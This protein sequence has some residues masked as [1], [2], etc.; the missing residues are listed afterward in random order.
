MT[1]D[2]KKE[3]ILRVKKMNTILRKLYP[4]AVIALN[5]SNP[6]ELMV[7]VQLSAQ[8]TDKRVNI[9]TEKLFKKYTTVG[10]YA[11]ARQVEF[12]KDIFSCGFYRNKARN[13]IAAARMVEEKYKGEIPRTLKEL[14]LIPGVARKTAN[15]VL[16]NLYEM[17]EGIAVDTHVRRF[18]IRFDLSDFK[19]P[20]RIERDLM[21]IMPTSEWWGFNHR[22]VHYGRDICPARK[23][24]CKDHP[25]TKIY[26]SADALW[27]KA[28]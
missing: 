9:V 11:R 13:I 18:A 22:L 7:A 5:F 1:L 12:E 16:S 14:L 6:W 10:A 8:C 25:L 2:K 4:E 26:P 21:E 24:D 17:A 15:V 19:D 23:H 27:P 3:R 28:H 20:V